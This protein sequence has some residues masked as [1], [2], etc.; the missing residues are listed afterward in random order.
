MCLSHGS[1]NSV[2]QEI[3]PDAPPAKLDPSIKTGIL[4]I[5]G[6]LMFIRMFVIFMQGISSGLPLAITGSTLQ[7]WM[8]N[9][10]VDL[11]VIGIFSLV[12]LPYTFKFLWAPLMDRYAI[13]FIGRRK[14]WAIISQLGVAL[15]II[16]LSSCN[17]AENPWLVAACAVFIAFMSASQDI[18]LDAYRREYLQDQELGLGSSL[19]VNGYRVGMMIS[20]AFA[21]FLADQISWNEVYLVLAGIMFIAMAVMFFVPEP[22]LRATPPKTLIDAVVQPL[23]DYFKREGAWLFLL[24]ILLYKIG[25]TMAGSMTTPF[26]LDLGFTKT[27][28]GAIG[29]T[30]GLFSMLGGAFVG[31]ALMLRLS[32]TR[33]LVYFGILQMVSTAGFVALAYAGNNSLALALVVGFEAFTAGMGTSAFVAFMAKLT[34]VRFTATQYALL[35]SLMGVPRVILSAPTGW[36]AKEMGWVAFFIFCTL[37]ALPGLFLIKKFGKVETT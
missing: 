37:I 12:G 27:E 8:K 28:Y 30:V 23:T 14:G 19:F 10:N 4:S 9:S 18:V 13:P 6:D 26:I 20:G 35:S 32:M 33:S 31:G 1:D 36:M 25:D 29:K 16:A 34:N 5:K 21:L 3:H 22:K 15:G 11:T 24:F 2:F 17:P 7:A